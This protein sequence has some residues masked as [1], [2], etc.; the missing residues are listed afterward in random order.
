M[1]IIVLHGLEATAVGLRHKSRGRGP[2][3]H[4]VSWMGSAGEMSP[5][6]YRAATSDGHFYACQ[7]ALL[8]DLSLLRFHW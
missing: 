6:A 4:P 2:R 5:A 3:Q 1:I 7:V 8:N